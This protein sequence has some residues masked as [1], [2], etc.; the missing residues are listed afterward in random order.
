LGKFVGDHREE[1]ERAYQSDKGTMTGGMIKVEAAERSKKYFFIVSVMLSD[2]RAM[3]G[4]VPPREVVHGR[5]D[6]LWRN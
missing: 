4:L 2:I 3:T 1:C 6:V 5:N